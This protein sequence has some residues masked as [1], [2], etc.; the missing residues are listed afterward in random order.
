MMMGSAEELR[1]ALRSVP[2]SGGILR[3]VLVADVS[4]QQEQEEPEEDIIVEDADKGGCIILIQ[5][6]L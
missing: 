3:L 2:T 5:G 4:Q 6:Q 1:V